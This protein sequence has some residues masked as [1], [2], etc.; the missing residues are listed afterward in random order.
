M[1]YYHTTGVFIHIFRSL[2]H[3]IILRPTRTLSRLIS[4][5][6]GVNLYGGIHPPLLTPTHD[7]HQ[8]SLLRYVEV[9]VI[10]SEERLLSSLTAPE[11]TQVAVPPR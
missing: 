7:V 10:P 2:Q 11:Y 6:W 4:Q 9:K 5:C 1:M 8:L 3:Y